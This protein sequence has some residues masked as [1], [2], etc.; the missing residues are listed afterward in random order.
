MS[1][2][3]VCEL[4]DN[5]MPTN[6]TKKVRL[7][8]FCETCG[9]I[10]RIINHGDPVPSHITCPIC[11]AEVKMRDVVVTQP[12]AANSD[13][14]VW[15]CDN[16]GYKHVKRDTRTIYHCNNCGSKRMRV[17]MSNTPENSQTRHIEDKQIKHT[18][19]NRANNIISIW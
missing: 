17:I 4:K 3:T 2:Y 10:S 7:D 1:M 14:V 12:I 13:Y 11:D 19:L 16:C 6:E 8:A 5:N 18:D 15:L 9:K